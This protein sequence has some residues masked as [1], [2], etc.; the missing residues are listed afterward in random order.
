VRRIQETKLRRATI[1]KAARCLIA[2]LSIFTLWPLK[3]FCQ[4]ASTAPPQQSLTLQ[5]YIAELDR[6]S[7][8]LNASPVNS[9]A[10]HELRVTLPADW[11]VTAGDAHYSVATAWL[12]GALGQIERNPAAN[13]DALSQARRKLQTYREEAQALETST[14]SQNLAQSRARLDSILSAREF[15]GQRGP[16]WLDVLKARVWSWI[17]RQLERI[18]GRLGGAKTI[19]NVVAWTVIVLACLLLLLWT[20]R[21][22]MRGG[23]RSEMD[24][25][26]ATPV[27]RDWHRWLRDARAAAA[28]GD[29]RAAIH[30]AYWAAVVRMEETNALPEDRSRTP[31]E[32]LRLIRRES[33]D[34][35]PLLQLT[36]RFELVWYG[37]RSATDADW[38]DAMQQLETLGCLRSSTAA[39]SGS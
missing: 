19:G 31:R 33:A 30:A 1:C 9:A 10:I 11:T 14:A 2:L 8:V 18:F 21:F 12:S 4:T 16:S 36:Q 3:S 24:L 37:Y 39:I 26:G 23:T 29:Y 20:L 6:C 35:A 7:A 32:S 5:Q 15:R 22:L 38:S 25:R 34:Y 13:G 17:V 27:N 28:Q